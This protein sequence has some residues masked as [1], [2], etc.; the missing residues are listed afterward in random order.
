VSVNIIVYL[1]T[2]FIASAQPKLYLV[3][4]TT[5]KHTITYKLSVINKAIK[6]QVPTEESKL[7]LMYEFLGIP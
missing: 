3:H 1:Y 7:H 5:P 4:S 6:Q 2:Y